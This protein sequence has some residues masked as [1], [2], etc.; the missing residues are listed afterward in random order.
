MSGGQLQEVFGSDAMGQFAQQLGLAPGDAA[1][2]L[3]QLLPQVVDRMTPEGRIPDN[4]GDL[5]N[6]VLA[7]LQRGRGG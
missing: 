2:Q 1:D 6:Q 3:S 4:Q 7:A 5:V